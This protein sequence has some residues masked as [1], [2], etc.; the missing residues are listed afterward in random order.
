MSLIAFFAKTQRIGVIMVV[1]L[2]F[3]THS[4][5]LAHHPDRK[6]DPVTPRID[7]IPPLGNNLKPG[8]RRK[9]NRPSYW[10]GKI[11]YKIAPSSQEAMAWH[12]AVHAGAYEDPKKCL[13]LEQHYFYPKPWQTL[14][15][16][17]RPSTMMA[18]T[19]LEP[20]D[21]STEE[22]K[23]SIE[24]E[25]PVDPSDQPAEQDDL[26]LPELDTTPLD[27]STL[28]EPKT[29]PEPDLEEPKLAD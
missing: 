13:R 23:E 18:A 29:L 21:R 27:E 9:Y 10:E 17:P 6:C 8:H 19:E 15:V 20:I 26:D 5:T 11:A 1:C 16:G 22:A 28:S 12:R 25:V 3:T 24:D 14:R 7:L 2:C 4:S